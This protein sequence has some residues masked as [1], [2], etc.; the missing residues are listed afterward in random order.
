MQI[1]GALLY[2][3][4]GT[5]L[6]AQGGFKKFS[7]VIYRTRKFYCTP[8]TVARK[9]PR[10]CHQCKPTF[11]TVFKSIDQTT[12]RDPEALLVYSLRKA[13]SEAV[14]APHVAVERTSDVW[15]TKAEDSVWDAALAELA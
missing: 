1:D 3:L 6:L 12:A 15:G 11:V 13:V 4:I 8:M 7:N 5:P 10:V 14:E 2:D 9:C